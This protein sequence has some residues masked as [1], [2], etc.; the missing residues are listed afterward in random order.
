MTDHNPGEPRKR[1]KGMWIVL[2]LLLG[3]S[4]FMYVSIAYKI[5]HY[6]P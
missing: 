5:T 6:G 4:A 3:L 2:L 1:P